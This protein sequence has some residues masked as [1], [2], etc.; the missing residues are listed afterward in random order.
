MSATSP[1]TEFDHKLLEFVKVS[2]SHF[3]ESHDWTHAVK[4]TDN[5]HLIM[6]SLRDHYEYDLVNMAAMLHDVCDHKYPES[7]SSFELETFI[8]DN[9][10]KVDADRILAIINNVSY[11]KEAKGKNFRMN[12]YQSILLSVLVFYV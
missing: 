10:S 5:T 12:I 1:S 2:T 9:A 11:S 3:D 4:V 6:R 8:R 7:I